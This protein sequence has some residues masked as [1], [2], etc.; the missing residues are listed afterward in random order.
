MKVEGSYSFNADRRTVWDALMAPEVLAVCIPGCQKLESAG[1]DTYDVIMK[2]RMGAVIGT[3]T[4]RVTVADQMHLESYRMLVEGRGTGGSIK[5]EG[6]I[7]LAERNGT[8]EVK[9]VGDAQVSGIVARV[10]QRLMV[11]ASRMLMNQFFGCIKEKIE[12]QR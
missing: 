3:Y 12:S 10:G 8:T 2:V 11:S 5:G 6:A 4:G 9:L 7:R 1:E